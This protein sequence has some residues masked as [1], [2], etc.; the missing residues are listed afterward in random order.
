MARFPQLSLWTCCAAAAL[1]L[2]VGAETLF[3]KAAKIHTLSGAPL[4]PGQLVVKDGKIAAIGSDLTPP[5]GAKVIDLKDAVLMPGLIDGYSQTGAAAAAEQTEELTP[6]FKISAGLD[7]RARAFKEALADGVTAQLVAPDTNNVIGGQGCVV[8]SAGKSKADRLLADEVGLFI[9]TTGDP[10]SG[11]SSRGRPD[12]IYNRLPTNRMGV[13]WM[14][15]Q[16]FRFAKA[17][18]ESA[19]LDVLRQALAGERPVFAVARTEFE[20]GALFKIA[21]EAGLKK[22]ILADGYEA[23]KAARELAARRIPVLL[24]PLAT[25]VIQGGEFEKAYWNQPQALHEA[26]VAFA[27]TGPQLLEQARFAAR[28]GLPAE[29]ALAAIT[30]RPAEILG[31]AD[32]VGALAVG[33]DADFVVLSGDPLDFTTRIRDVA[34]GGVLLHPGR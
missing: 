32:R 10:G 23:H 7:W 5:A 30:K 13:I 18:K 31:V 19:D 3:V 1:A 2:P 22:L 12:T 20:I 25:T 15:R 11:N 14:L 34:V 24:D 33:K 17:G 26:G 28:H 27:L 29:A 21:D 9:T 4:A 8:K 16:Q 6:R